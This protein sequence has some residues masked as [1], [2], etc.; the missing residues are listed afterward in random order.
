MGRP[1]KGK[2]TREM[3]CLMIDGGLGEGAAGTS[4]LPQRDQPT[5]AP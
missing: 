2:A 3:S 4:S 5:P 1:G